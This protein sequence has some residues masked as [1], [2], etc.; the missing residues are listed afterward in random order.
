MPDLWPPVYLEMQKVTVNTPH[1]LLLHCW[2][3]IYILKK[4]FLKRDF[5]R[6]LVLNWNNTI[7]L[8]CSKHTLIWN[9]VA[10]SFRWIIFTN[11]YMTL[12]IS[13]NSTTKLLPHVSTECIDTCT[14]ELPCT[15]VICREMYTRELT[16]SSFKYTLVP[17]VC[18]FE[19]HL[20][21]YTKISHNKINS[22][23]AASWLASYHSYDHSMQIKWH[24]WSSICRSIVTPLLR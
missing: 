14:W 24:L 11:S 17:D 22:P 5:R 23:E 1:V 16:L 12:E 19:Q 6:Y 10:G 8:Q 21:Q 20:V 2:S 4:I 9:L 13:K 3:I 15:T 7:T 18:K